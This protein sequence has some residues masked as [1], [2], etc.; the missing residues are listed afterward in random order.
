MVAATVFIVALVVV[1]LVVLT[2]YFLGRASEADSR[3]LA[4]ARAEGVAATL[5]LRNGRVHVV[6]SATDTLDRLAWVYDAAGH[7]LDGIPPANLARPA[8][9]LAG[10]GVQ[11][12][13]T[14]GTDLLYADPV[15]VGGRTIG[16]SV[17]TVDLQPYERSE[18]RGLWASL[19]LGLA[20][21]LL[22]GGVAAAV[23]RQALRTVHRM[24]ATADA[25]QEHDLERRFGLGP[26]VDEISE[27]GRTMDHMLDRISQALAAERRLT[28]ELAHEL[29]TPVTVIRTEAQLAQRT[30]SPDAEEGLAA[31]VTATKDLESSIR[32]L[33]DAARARDLG[34]GSC[35]LPAALEP[36]LERLRA[37]GLVVRTE[38]GGVVPASGELVRALLAPLLDNAARYAVRE[39]VVRIEPG[40]HLTL[41]VRDDGP[42]IAAGDEDRVFQAGWTTSDGGN[43]LGLPVV[44]RL[45][46]SMGGTVRAVAGP[47]GHVVVELPG[48]EA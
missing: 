34:E 17:A 1:V 3:S 26:P 42:G 11:A 25:W 36:L 47:G 10:R 24:A 44:R 13:R 35:V 28:D 45:A 14:V 37:S 16:T 21:V 8:A 12:Y 2:Q 15:V 39:V 43:G 48:R 31:I 38:G 33:L 41:H 27:L 5:E 29:R 18:S 46:A 7:V 19:A 40:E 20:T 4:R 6:E 23:T 32:T 9:R 30:A 22:A